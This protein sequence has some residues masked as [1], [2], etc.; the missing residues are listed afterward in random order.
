MIFLIS[1][2]HYAYN[3]LEIIEYVARVMTQLQHRRDQFAFTIAQKQKKPFSGTL[4]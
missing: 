4:K 1:T 2:L 3:M